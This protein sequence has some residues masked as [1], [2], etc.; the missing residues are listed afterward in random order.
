MLPTDPLLKSILA[1]FATKDTNWAA[2]TVLCYDYLLTFDDERSLVWS[3]KWSIGKILFLLTRYSPFVDIIL[4]I[5]LETGTF[6]SAETCRSL[7]LTAVIVEVL[8]ISFAEAILILRTW[9]LWDHSRPIIISLSAGLTVAIALSGV[10]LALFLSSITFIVE[11]D[12]CILTEASR[13]AAVA[14]VFVTVMLFETMVLILTAIKAWHHLRQPRSDLA[15]V[16]YRDG[17]CFFL[18][19]NLFSIANVLVLINSDHISPDLMLT[20]QRVMHSILSGRLLIN[21]RQQV[22]SPVTA[23]EGKLE[24]QVVFAS[25]PP[26]LSAASSMLTSVPGQEY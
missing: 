17:L 23:S 26:S 12:I 22:A 9:A 13:A 11:E 7:Y 3:S 19:I 24:N 4:A 16:I 6:R 10:L 15:T 2:V 5:I 18:F 20:L 1:G 25:G 14:G 21:L 8:G